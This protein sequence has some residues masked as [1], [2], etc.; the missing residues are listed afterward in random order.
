MLAG[1][2]DMAPARRSALIAHHS[3]GIHTLCPLDGA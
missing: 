3:L 1:T 2:T